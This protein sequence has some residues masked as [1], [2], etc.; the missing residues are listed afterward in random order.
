M[1]PLYEDDLEENEDD[2]LGQPTPADSIA[3]P[4]TTPERVFKRIAD[5][6][7]PPDAT[8]ASPETEAKMPEAQYGVDPAAQARADSLRFNAGIG[9]AINALSEGTGYKPDNSGYDALDKEAEKGLDRAGNVKKMIAQ[10]QIRARQSQDLNDYRNKSLDVK[11]QIADQMSQD[12]AERNT[13]SA[14]A[15]QTAEDT[16]RFDKLGTLLDSSG[17][18]S[19]NFGKSGAMIQAAD[20]VDA[21]F[22]QYPDG[23]IPKAQSTE[24][25]TAV[26]A[27]VGGGSVQS[28]HQLD[29]V[30]PSSVKGDANA[31]IGWL[32]NEPRGMEQQAFMKNL[33]ESAAREREVAQEQ[34]DAVK[35]Q[36]LGAFA[37]L[38]KRNPDRFNQIIRAAGMDPANYD[39]I[40]GQYKAPKKATPEGGSMAEAARKELERRKAQRAAGGLK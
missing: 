36:R 15:K 16:K 14:E 11:K 29:A 35:A 30:T 17:A 25:A 37:D 40:S 27:M 18:R 3:G 7:N 1:T 33:Q 38:A 6:R 8:A 31:T 23:N 39:Q 21:L 34:I 12:R 2:I 26:A 19:G 24:L 9:R 20:R 10:N 32:L 28:Q 5:M 4:Q 22:K 13:G